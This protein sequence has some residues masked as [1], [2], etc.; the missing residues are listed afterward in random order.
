MSRT[1]GAFGVAS[2]VLALALLAS[3]ATLV[4]ASSPAALLQQIVAERAVWGQPLE[5]P[6]GERPLDSFFA[7][8]ARTALKQNG[9]IA[10]VAHYGDSLI[11]M[12]LVAGQM[13]RRL[14][15]KYGDAGHGF[16]HVARPQPWYRPYDILHEPA[17]AW[18]AYALYDTGRKDRRFG[19]GG[20]VSFAFKAGA[21]SIIGT[22]DK[23]KIGRA[24]S[25]FEILFPID[26]QNGPLAVALDGKKLG[27]LNGN[28]T[29]ARDAYAEI[30]VADG[31]HKLE[32][33]G[34]NQGARAYG[35]VLE[36]DAT[37]VVY[38]SLGVNG[39]GIGSYLT[40]ERQHW[41]DQLRHR[42]PDL[43]VLSFGGNEAR[44]NFDPEAVKQNTKEVI[45]I[46]RQALPQASILLV[47]PGDSA[48]KI[49][50]GLVSAP[51]LPKVLAKQRE[52]A[53]ESKIAYWS[54][55]DAMGGAGSM[56][57]WYE[58]NPRLGAGDLLHPT[59]KGGEVL[60]DMMFNAV[61]QGFGEYLE[62]KGLPPAAAPAPRQSPLAKVELQ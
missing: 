23:G 41:I 61:L 25:R 56:A 35:V 22:S 6:A 45:A 58:A 52:A 33:T 34:V 54:M 24:V 36:R 38:D 10:R 44:S 39:I 28:E 47:G 27:T 1:S 12:D 59:P 19:Y 62:R 37:G 15:D 60:G 55:F 9:A 5:Y 3:V 51:L 18:I 14:Q 43:V 8:L 30:R 16:V 26:P 40:I 4:W 11:E 17:A 50:T 2:A 46:V 7:A 20:G 53:M 32:L 48:V 42:R 31:S 21:K 49:G 29:T 57:K 13:R